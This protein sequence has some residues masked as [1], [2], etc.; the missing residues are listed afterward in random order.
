MFVDLIYNF[1]Q[2]MPH[3]RSKQ[4]SKIPQFSKLVN[5]PPALESPILGE[6]EAIRGLPAPEQQRFNPRVA[7]YT[8]A[9]V[10]VLVG[11]LVVGVKSK[12]IM[13]RWEVFHLD[14]NLMVA[15]KRVREVVAG[16]ED[17]RVSRL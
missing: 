8:M 6:N 3:P 4:I 11:G 7:L 2:T 1:D 5:S 16:W 12:E 15:T 17:C 9:F 14:S 13:E 10:G